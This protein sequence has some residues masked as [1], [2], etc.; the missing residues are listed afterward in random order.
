MQKV[1]LPVARASRCVTAGSANLPARLKICTLKATAHRQGLVRIFST[2]LKHSNHVPS[3]PPLASGLPA[4]VS[5]DGLDR[6]PH[7]SSARGVLRGLD[8]AG[9]AV[10]AAGGAVAAAATGFDVLG[11][12]AVGTVT[13]VGGGTMRDLVIL[14]RAPFWSGAA[15]DGG[16]PEYLLIA[17]MA[18]LGAFYAFPLV[19]EGAWAKDAAP[20]AV[21]LGAFAVIGAMNGARAGLPMAQSLLCGVRYRRGRCPR[22]DPK[23]PRAHLPLPQR[24]VRLCRC[25]W[26]SCLPWRQQVRRALFWCKSS[27][28]CGSYSACAWGSG[29]IWTETADK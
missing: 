13:A 21:S 20:D 5:P 18:A 16:E 27:S 26:R 24:V 7:F 2:N 25:Q 8:W 12:V 19:G 29:C 17:A 14:A 23:A 28:R 22:H 10:F 6:I 9:T 3:F 4:A 1:L 15:E 11:A